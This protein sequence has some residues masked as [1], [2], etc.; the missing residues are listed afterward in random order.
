[1]TSLYSYKPLLLTTFKET[2]SQEK[3]AFK[4]GVQASIINTVVHTPISM[5]GGAKFC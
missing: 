4:K 5:R 2:V 3:L 1:M